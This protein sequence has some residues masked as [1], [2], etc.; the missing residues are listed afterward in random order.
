M[1]HFTSLSRQS[2]R[3]AVTRVEA[4]DRAAVDKI[5][6]AVKSIQR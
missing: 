6:R 4:T 5:R 3:P 1:H 2:N